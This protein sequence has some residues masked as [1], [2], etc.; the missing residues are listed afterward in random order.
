LHRIVSD[1]VHGVTEF[2]DTARATVANMGAEVGATTSTFP[3][4]SHMRDYLVA[5]GRAPVA[6]A[7]DEAASRGFLEADKDAE[8]DEVIPIVRQRNL[9][10]GKKLNCL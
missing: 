4:T 8:Y 3:Y 7:A 9:S 6:K 1:E 2:D 10:L 5:T